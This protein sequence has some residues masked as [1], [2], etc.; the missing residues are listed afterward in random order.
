MSADRR[1]RGDAT[2]SEEKGETGGRGDEPRVGVE[3]STPERTLPVL[4]LGALAATLGSWCELGGIF[5]GAMAGEPMGFKAGDC[6][7]LA[8]GVMEGVPREVIAGD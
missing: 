7:L 5:L 3:C 4:G 6:D 2:A 1:P 8:L